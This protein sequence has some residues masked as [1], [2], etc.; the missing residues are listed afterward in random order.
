MQGF[1]TCMVIGRG[2]DSNS[3]QKKSASFT[4][5]A[6]PSLDKTL[7]EHEAKMKEAV[8]DPHEGFA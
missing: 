7:E 1:R 2:V 3:A 8:N 4:K 5:S 6:I